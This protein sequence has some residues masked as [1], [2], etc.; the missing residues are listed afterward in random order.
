MAHA[1]NPSREVRKES[2]CFVASIRL[3]WATQQDHTPKMGAEDVR[4]GA[5]LVDCLQRALTKPWVYPQ[6]C[7]NC[8][9]TLLYPST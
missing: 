7:I 1:S 6:H 9:D 2:C 4:V 3:A 5:Q 8:V